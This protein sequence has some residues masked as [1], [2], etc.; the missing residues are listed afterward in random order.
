[1]HGELH[2][3]AVLAQGVVQFAHA[4]LGLGHGHAVAGDDDHAAGG[5]HDLGRVFGRGALDGAL[6]GVALAGLN[7]PESAEQHVGERAIHRLAHDDRED[8]ARGAVQ[9]PGGDQQ[10]SSDFPV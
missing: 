6:F 1:M 2:V 9:G 5:R 8:Q 4:V 3:H 7:L 10:Q